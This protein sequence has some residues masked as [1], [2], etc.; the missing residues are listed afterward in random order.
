MP[1]SFRF[2]CMVSA[3]AVAVLLVLAIGLA[4]PTRA[5]AQAGGAAPAPLT[6]AQQQQALA[7]LN[8]TMGMIKQATAAWHDNPGVFPPDGPPPGQLISAIEKEYPDLG[9]NRII[10]INL[11]P[12]QD[13]SM[14]NMW[15]VTFESKTKIYG[16]NIVYCTVS[17]Y[18]PGHPTNPVS[19]PTAGGILFVDPSFTAQLILAQLTGAGHDL[20]DLA[21]WVN[22][23]VPPGQGAL[24]AATGAAVVSIINAFA[25]MGAAKPPPMPSVAGT[26]M[27]GMNWYTW[28]GKWYLWSGYGKPIPASVY[29]FSDQSLVGDKL[30]IFTQPVPGYG[31]ITRSVLD[32]FGQNGAIDG[33]T[34]RTRL[35]P[36]RWRAL[37]AADKQATA[38]ALATDVAKAYG[39]DPAT[40]NIQFVHDPNAGLRGSWNNNS[41]VLK[42]NTNA[43]AF[44]S[45]YGLA[46]TIGHELRHAAQSDPNHPLG[47]ANAEYRRLITYNKNNYIP[48]GTDFTRY[49]SQLYE[50]DAEACGEAVG[51]AVLN[52]ALGVPQ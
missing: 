48:S 37:T 14:A 49:A 19:T 36:T 9:C 47:G 11:M 29:G 34:M 25:L 26:K 22:S 32:G 33:A 16:M 12:E 43:T 6:Q 42:I 13:E 38:R 40:V 28:G 46:R 7:S 39:I 5:R 2:A 45:P 3:A 10:C 17:F 31:G 18:E 41:R 4:A 44:N 24:G 30:G 1:R 8:E 35:E 15:A 23:N 50:R 27:K 20:G 21:S 51:R 52:H